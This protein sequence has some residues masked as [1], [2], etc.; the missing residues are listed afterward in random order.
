MLE[1]Y[2]TN[3][4][5]GYDKNETPD[6]IS[7]LTSASPDLMVVLTSFGQPFASP[8]DV[9]PALV[10]IIDRLGGTG[11]LKTRLVQRDNN[12]IPT[13]YTLITSSD[14]NI[15]NMPDKVIEE[16][17]LFPNQTG[18]LK[19]L[20]GKD[21]NNQWTVFSLLPDRTNSNSTT[22]LSSFDWQTVGCQPAQDWPAWTP[23]QQNAYIDLTS[24]HYPAIR[25]SLG[26]MA[27]VCPPIRS[28]YSGVIGGGGSAALRIPYTGLNYFP[29]GDYSPEDFQPVVTQLRKEQGYLGNV[30]AIYN[31]F[32]NVTGAAQGLL[33]SE[34]A[35]I[36]RNFDA[37]LAQQNQSAA[38]TGTLR[39]P[40]S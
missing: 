36:A 6:L 31:L 10:R 19:A 11:E 9:D 5:S 27:D 40:T 37:G 17:T 32:N 13:G 15:T 39:R 35:K 22:Q 23:N 24:P 29:N 12:G 8:K 38:T 14:A 26:C 28:Y 18:S 34:L 2:I 20:L 16:T 3:V 30:Q 1:N 25:E 21:R 7:A 4:A 33:Q